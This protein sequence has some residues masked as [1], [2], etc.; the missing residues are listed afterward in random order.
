MGLF[1]FHDSFD[2]Q[3]KELDKAIKKEK[4][5]FE[6]E[7]RNGHSAGGFFGCRHIGMCEVCYNKNSSLCRSCCSGE[8][9]RRCYFIRRC[10]FGANKLG[11]F[12][13]EY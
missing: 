9:S 4:E 2:S 1:D 5:A 8:G 10:H 6:K 11:G 3:N 7:A 13:E 12:R